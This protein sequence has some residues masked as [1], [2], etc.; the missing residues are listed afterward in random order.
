MNPGPIKQAMSMRGLCEAGMRLP[1][2]PVSENT[3]RLLEQALT[4]AGA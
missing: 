1:M 4:A 3:C 2:T